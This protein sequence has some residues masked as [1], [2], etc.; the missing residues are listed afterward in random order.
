MKNWQRFFW[1]SVL[2]IIPGGAK[3]KTRIIKKHHLLGS[4]GENCNIQGWKL[5]LHSELVFLH[6]NVRIAS[7]VG[8]VTH[9]G[10]YRMLNKKYDTA[11]FIEKVGVI[12]IMDNVFVGSGT[13]ILYNVRIGSNVIIGSD[14]LVNRDVPDNSVYAGVPAR[15]I[16]SFDEYEKK[17]RK[18]SNL[19]KERYGIDEMPCMNRVLAFKRHDYFLKDKKDEHIN[20]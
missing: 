9:D 2:R 1:N 12:E 14:S 11:D 4:I 8:F 18:Y 3:R 10:I 5:P 13:R 6:D 7:H 20:I 16:C 17:A 15:Y 19:V